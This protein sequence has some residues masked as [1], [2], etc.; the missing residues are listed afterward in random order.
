MPFHL[1]LQFY[2]YPSYVTGTSCKKAP[3]MKIFLIRHAGIRSSQ[4]V[5][6]RRQR[7]GG[8]RVVSWLWS[9]ARRS[10]DVATL[11]RVVSWPA[12]HSTLHPLG[13]RN[14]RPRQSN[15]A[16][17][18][19]ETT[20]KLTNPRKPPLF[21]TPSTPYRAPHPPS[22]PFTTGLF[23]AS[24]YISLCDSILVKTRKTISLN[25]AWVMKRRLA[26]QI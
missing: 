17:T 22:A 26:L 8:Q 2:N 9:I 15:G 11:R 18:H 21:R 4:N 10:T 25:F 23:P 24:I 6:R 12:A 13:S 14:P 7:R 5:R 16:L 20:R 3:L 19:S 1:L